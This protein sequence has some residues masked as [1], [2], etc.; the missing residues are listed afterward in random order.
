MLFRAPKTLAE[1]AL[2][3]EKIEAIKEQIG[4]ATRTPARRWKGVLRRNSFA[5]AIRGSNS[6]EGYNV[7]VDD[8]I[9]AAEG[10]EPL[11]AS[12]EAWAAVTAYRKAMTYVLQSADATTFVYSSDLIKSIHF[13]MLD[14]DLEKSPG[15][16]RAGPI[17][18]RDEE[19]DENV[20]EGPPA[21]L[22]PGLMDELCADLQADTSSSVVVRAAMAHLNLVMIHPF[23]DGNGRMARILQ[24]LVLARG[25]TLDPLFCSIEEYLGGNTRAYYDVLSVVGAGRWQPKRDAR[26]WIRFC[27]TAH[28]RQAV[29]HVRRV[30]QLGRIWTLAEEQLVA[31]GLPERAAVAVVD[32]GMNFRVR[33]AT[34]RPAAGV[35]DQVASRDLK[36]LVDA[37]FLVPKGERRGRFYIAS[38]KLRELVSGVPK[39]GPVEDPFERRS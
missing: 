36:A 38:P 19:R 30:E 7:T 11:E 27:L 10:E 28:Y 26:P 35:S 8:A 17:F 25:G 31:L 6:I 14:Y 22:L 20:Y 2:V 24:A 16:W 37:G 34:Y 15:K 3:L 29:T 9:A 13:M 21:E 23:R 32:A 5:R 1:E 12:Q 4:A 39:P 18:V 33:N